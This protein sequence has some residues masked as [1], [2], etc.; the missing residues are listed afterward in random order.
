MHRNMSKAY[1]ISGEEAVSGY[2]AVMQNLMS[3]DVR[4]QFA[5]FHLR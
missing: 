2:W 1:A 5:S 3:E 4:E